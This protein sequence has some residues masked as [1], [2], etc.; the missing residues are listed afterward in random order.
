MLA[1]IF[2]SL[3]LREERVSRIGMYVRRCFVRCKL[4][5]R[6]HKMSRIRPTH[7]RM[8]MKRQTIIQR[9]TMNGKIIFNLWF[10]SHDSHENFVLIKEERNKS[11]TNAQN[12]MKIWVCQREK[13]N[14][15]IS[16]LLTSAN[17]FSRALEL[18]SSEKKARLSSS[19]DALNRFDSIRPTIFLVFFPVHFQ[20]YRLCRPCV[21]QYHH[22]CHHSL[23][24][25]H[26]IF[27]RQLST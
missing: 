7:A 25:C 20:L 19:V 10:Y 22:R 12:E 15:S 2:V 27:R 1:S 9:Q 26:H 24:C 17:C 4:R 18:I 14:I 6:L 11:K 3:Y 13:K 21:I 23:Q 16:A 5:S 8:K